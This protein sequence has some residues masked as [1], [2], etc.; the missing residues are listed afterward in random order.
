MNIL[1]P[2]TAL[3]IAC[4][5]SPLTLA[6]NLEEI[7]ITSSRVPMPLR[8]VGT[9][10]SVV[11]ASEIERR[12]FASLYDILR[13]QPAIGVSNSGGAGKVTA[14]RIRGEEGFRTQ[15]L[16]DGINISDT[17]GTQIGPKLEH[18]MSAGINRV[19]ILRGPQ[20]LMYGADAGGIISISTDAPREGFT[21]EVNAE[22]GRYGT[23]QLG[24][25][26]GGGN[27]TVDFS[28]S[29][30]D[31]ETDGFNT[32]TTDTSLR[33][34]DGYENTTLH[35]RLGWNVSDDLRLQFVARDVSGKNEFDGCF[36]SQSTDLCNDDYD[37]S[38]WRAVA[39]Y[40]RGAFTHQLS[41]DK[42]KTE[43]ESFSDG[44]LSFTGD[45]E[46]E[47]W[48]Y[49]G[50]FS[51]S[52]ALRLVYG[53]D[54]ETSSLEDGNLNPERDQEGYYAEY[55]GSFNNDLFITGGVRYDDNDDFGTHTSYRVSGA[56]VFDLNGGDL[57][58]RGTYG[59]GFRAPALSELAYN[60]RDGAYLPASEVILKEEESKGYDIGLSWYSDSGLVLEAVY[61][62]QT[63]TDEIFFDLDSFSGYLQGDGDIDSSG[64][65][66][67]GEIT[68]FD[69]LTVSGNYTYNDTKDSSGESRIRRPEHL[70]NIAVNWRGLDEKLLLGLNMRGSY[71]STNSVFGSIV[72][73]DD[74]EVIDINASYEI[75]QG[76]Q[77]YGRVENLLDE[78]YQEV[79]DYNTSGAAAY[80]GVRYSF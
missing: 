51:S 15:V 52:D 6:N 76:L 56:Y 66:L 4:A 73:L 18:L 24:A 60:A 61:F 55:Q 49:L 26:L 79:T 19:E 17:S 39:D 13:S 75:L 9:S 23:Q 80:A 32:K 20:G 10:V 67:I 58:L 25:N 53:V 62:D 22:V 11:T 71:D 65:E 37:Q 63:V 38:A 31:F 74:Y 78:D 59:T 35:G 1:F 77:I 41:Y 34:D 27:D 28:L 68:L 70:A 40:T 42:N 3:A 30:S 45:G 44:L 2:V 64:V 47:S 12:G 43:R 54:F 50:S 5:A 72:E 33:D 16:I 36:S 57:K 21:G 14:L 29:L 8:Q 46:L 48:G 7:I 69:T